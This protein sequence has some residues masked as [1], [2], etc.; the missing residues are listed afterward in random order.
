MRAR[1]QVQS[2]ELRSKEEECR[3]GSEGKRIKLNRGAELSTK[4][5]D[6]FALDWLRSPLFALL[7]LPDR[8]N[9]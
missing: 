4:I 9:K 3:I 7:S 8:S 2:K 6:A 5:F 1:S